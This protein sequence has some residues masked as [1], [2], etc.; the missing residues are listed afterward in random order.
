MSSYFIFSQ[1]LRPQSPPQPMHLSI[2]PGKYV[3]QARQLL[4]AGVPS[5]CA[6]ISADF[7]INQTSTGGDVASDS[8][9]TGS[10]ST[11]SSGAG[12]NCL[13][14]VQTASPSIPH[15]DRQQ[16]S[17]SNS[18]FVQSLAPCALHSASASVHDAS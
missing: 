2:S 16:T 7:S 1:T 6:Q 11:V 18:S 17:F 9:S 14:E 3:L 13:D 8:S 15:P 5:Y 10:A 12:R 4:K